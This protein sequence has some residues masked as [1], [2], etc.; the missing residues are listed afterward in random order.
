MTPDGIA[1]LN[2]RT[3][4]TSD[5]VHMGK[6]WESYFDMAGF[7]F[8]IHTC[9]GNEPKKNNLEDEYECDEG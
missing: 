7:L 9:G 3:K 4:F 2:R 5:I 8:Y 1:H 6:D